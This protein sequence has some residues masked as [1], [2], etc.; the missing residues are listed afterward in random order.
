MAIFFGDKFVDSCFP[1]VKSS[2]DSF[3]VVWIIHFR[4]QSIGVGSFGAKATGGLSGGSGG[5]RC[6]ATLFGGQ[7]ASPYRL[8]RFGFGFTN[9]VDPACAPFKVAGTVVSDSGGSRK[10]ECAWI[11]TLPVGASWV[12]VVIDENGSG[13]RVR[14][15]ECVSRSILAR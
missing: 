10:L 9:P 2:G 1:F 15:N 3:G 4:S 5:G 6:G 13:L 11:V 7:S 12:L 14:S 8:G